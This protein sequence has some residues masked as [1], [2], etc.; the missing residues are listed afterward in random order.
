MNADGWGSPFRLNRAF[1]VAQIFTVRVKVLLPNG[2]VMDAN[3]GDSEPIKRTALSHQHAG[4][5]SR[6]AATVEDGRFHSLKPVR[7]IWFRIWSRICRPG[8]S[9]Q[10]FG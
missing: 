7:G 2:V 6:F 4:G 1:L 5:I 8:I 10:E 3:V 9:G